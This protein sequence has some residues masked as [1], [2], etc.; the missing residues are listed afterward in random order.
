MRI[1]TIRL[2]KWKGQ[3]ITHDLG[4][5]TVLYGPNDQGKSGVMDAIR[6]A[7]SGDSEIGARP[8]AIAQL[9][10]PV[11]GKVTVA[12]DGGT[13]WSR[14]ITVDYEGNAKTEFAWNG[15][16][17]SLKT[18]ER[19]LYD[20]IGAFPIML[21][22]RLFFDLSADKQRELVYGLCIESPICVPAG[23]KKAFRD[24]VIAEIDRLQAAHTSEEAE[25]FT[26]RM[27]VTSVEAFIASADLIL[28]NLRARLAELQKTIRTLSDKKAGMTVTSRTAEVIAEELALARSNRDVVV[29]DA[30][31]ANEREK[32][33][34]RLEE[35]IKIAE[36]DCK[37]AKTALEEHEAKKPDVEP[38]RAGAKEAR[39]KAMSDAGMKVLEEG[40]ANLE[41]K[42]LKLDGQ[43]EE[44]ERHLRTYDE[45]VAQVV[46]SPFPRL[47]ASLA[48]LTLHIAPDGRACF[49]E[50]VAMVG[51][52]YQDLPGDLESLQKERK[53]VEV[54]LDEIQERAKKMWD[55]RTVLI[56]K[57]TAAMA[58]RQ[59]ADRLEVV[60][61]GVKQEL[62]RW[63]TNVMNL[64]HKH[65]HA[66]VEEVEARHE[67]ETL[68][69]DSVHVSLEVLDENKAGLDK[70]I[71]G[72]ESEREAQR[73]LQETEALLEE[74]QANA[75]TCE[76]RLEIGKGIAKNARA[77]RDSF[78][79]RLVEPI[80]AGMRSLLGKDSGVFCDLGSG[81][82]AVLDFGFDGYPYVVLG[83][84]KRV[85]FDAA[86]IVALTEIANP[87]LRLLFLEASEADFENLAR[88]MRML[89]KVEHG[90]VV[91]TT[92]LR[93]NDAMLSDKWRGICLD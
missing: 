34:V 21:N 74:T 84:G 51:E 22:R 66:F 43:N 18:G 81:D 17:V 42:A 56:T 11:G 69:A 7:V 47:W 27:D 72:L 16:P 89:E 76:R 12:L 54:R 82:K 57:Q 6:F 75:S 29:R 4:P 59:E 83:G 19:E 36:C 45:M 62:F 60:F 44:G 63:E 68:L 9:V 1:R 53:E 40:I 15:L 13:S 55:G 52:A 90:N 87:P 32:A 88:L 37:S 25:Y 80:V 48:F 30:G 50:I 28:N 86:F 92:Y 65:K 49:D 3:T 33:I 35:T 10:G 73:S 5:R 79:A 58:V 46:G 64:G 85:L 77:I 26:T 91:I 71:S 14:A 39:D 70:L 20:R 93:P 8:G 23:S 24:L 2:E 38:S 41:F 61:V 78:M 31:E 67:L